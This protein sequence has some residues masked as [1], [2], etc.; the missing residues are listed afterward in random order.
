MFVHKEKRNLIHFYMLYNYVG[1]CTQQ[2]SYSIGHLLGTV[3]TQRLDSD[4]VVTV[5]NCRQHG[6]HAPPW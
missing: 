2:N 5:D 6:D 3:A 1:I 4:G